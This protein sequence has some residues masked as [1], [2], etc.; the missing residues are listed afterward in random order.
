MQEEGQIMDAFSTCS[1]P[2]A[3]AMHSTVLVDR[4]VGCLLGQALGDAVGAPYEGMPADHVFWM[5]G[6]ASDLVRNPDGDLLRY[7]DD[8]QMM[9]GV[10]ET[11][12]EHGSIIEDALGQR[13]V[14]HYDP[15]R[16]YGPG[17]RRILEA[18]AAG[19]DGRHLAATIFPGGSLGNG[20]AMRVAPIGLVFHQDLDRVVEQA[21]LSALPTHVHPLGIEGAQLFALATALVVREEGFDRRRFYR[22][23]LD[24]C[25]S[26][27]FRWA[28]TSAAKLRR[29]H[30]LALLGSSLEAHRSVVTA[31]ACFTTGASSFEE[32]VAR[33]VSLGDDT[34]T[35]AAMAGALVG[36]HLGKN[37]LP[38]RLLEQLENGTEGRE[39]IEDLARRLH[40][41]Y[42]AAQGTLP[43]GD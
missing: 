8:T 41:R 37:A 4:F 43:A 19:G 5:L 25:C 17:A 11:L 27:E 9:I 34:D 28:L 30:S 20:A 1:L 40:G 36:A 23:L 33:A 6:P 14:A 21:R 31:I 35:L 12:V 7:T 10:A 39:Y 32:V 13:F 2:R 16:G 38:A 15:Q 24:H 29:R 3:S 22:T 26:E 18:M 42:L